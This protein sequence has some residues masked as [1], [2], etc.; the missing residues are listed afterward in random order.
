MAIK[1]SDFSHVAHFIVLIAHTVAIDV[2]LGEQAIFYVVAARGSDTTVV[3]GIRRVCAATCFKHGD[4]TRAYS[5]IAVD[6]LT[7][8]PIFIVNGFDDLTTPL[9]AR[10]CESGK[11]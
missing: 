1:I 10:C 9:D 2:G 5:V 3:V 11:N 7:Y 8:L 4:S 6:N